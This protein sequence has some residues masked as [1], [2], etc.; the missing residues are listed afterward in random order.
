[1]QKLYLSLVATLITLT[2]RAS[3][4]QQLPGHF[5]GFDAD[6]GITVADDFQL[7][8]Q[9]LLGGLIW[10]GGDYSP[11][12]SQDDFTVKLYLDNGGHPGS[13]MAQFAFGAVSKTATG[14]YV[15]APELYP[16]YEYSASFS[17][18]FVAQPGVRYWVSVANYPSGFWLWE[19]SGS[20]LN[21]GGATQFQWRR[22]AAVPGQHGLP[23]Y[24]GSGTKRRDRYG[25]SGRRHVV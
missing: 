7:N 20:S 8:Q 14:N 23:A 3:D 15:N 21:L 24:N 11:P 19:A 17:S 6:P 5:G 1:M 22:L 18:P 9:T 12:P 25:S 2:S 4:Y 10:W 13:V 16:E